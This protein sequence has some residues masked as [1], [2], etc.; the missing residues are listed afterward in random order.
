MN[1]PADPS[2]A[3]ARVLDRLRNVRT[4]ANGWTARCPAHDDQE[5]SLS[6]GPCDDGRVLLK[7][8]A[9]CAIETVVQ[10]LNMEMKDL[11]ADQWGGGS[12]TSLNNIATLQQ[13]GEKH[14]NPN[15]S[16]NP[17]KGKGRA[18]PGCSLADY[19]DAKRLPIDFLTGL[20]LRDLSYMKTP[21]I[22]MPYFGES[23]ETLA[24]RFRLAMKGDRFRWKS[25]DK[26]CLYGLWRLKEARAAGFVVLVEGESDCHT[27]WHHEIPAIGIPGAANWQEA[28]DAHHLD[29]IALIYI[30][31]EPDSGGEAVKRWLAKSSIQDRVKLVDLGEFKDT[32]GLHLAGAGQFQERWHAAIAG[33]VDWSEQK[34]AQAR[35]AQGQ[36]W[37]Q[38]KDL[39]ESPDIL[40]RVS[41]TLEGAGVVGER[42]TVKLLYLALISRFFDRPISVVMKGPSSGGK[43]YLVDQVL[44]LFPDHCYY[45]LTSMSDKALAYGDEPLSHR[46]L[47][48]FEAAGMEGETA[49]YMIRSLLS[50]GRIRYETVEKTP[51]GLKPRL[52]ER[53][54]PTGLIITTTRARLHPENETRL[55]SLTVTDTQAQTRAVLGALAAE[56]D[57]GEI[58]LSQWH[59]LQSWLDGADHGTT[60]PYAQKLAEM[61]PPIAVRLRRD[62]KQILNLIRAHALLFQAQRKRNDKGR[63]VATIADYAAIYDLCIDVVAEGVEATVS[64]AVGRPSRR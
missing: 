23:S 3:V 21:A 37:L 15:G 35:A 1:V 26:P 6:V 62:F 64:P 63:I 60:V 17:G 39:A 49:T 47:V 46:Y 5:N 41:A 34:A 32:S 59:A 48:I 4:D 58:D 29:G 38:C 54:G 61:V 10:V 40:D 43:S 13:S 11:F 28:R 51:D 16:A 12:S 2:G 19:A 55:L 8:H 50:E 31:V 14:S 25:G 30:V 52:I 36:A 56:D 27:A 44:K 7:C 22:R 57:D 53:E 9:G 42:R 24:V 33:A 45:A 20:G 18:I